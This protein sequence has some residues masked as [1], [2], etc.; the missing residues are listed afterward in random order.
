MAISLL[1]KT[2]VSSCY[3]RHQRCRNNTHNTREDG[4]CIKMNK[5]QRFLLHE[6]F[7]QASRRSFCFTRVMNTSFT[8]TLEHWPCSLKAQSWQISKLLMRWNLKIKSQSPT[9][10]HKEG[11]KKILVSLQA[12]GAGKGPVAVPPCSRACVGGQLI[13]VREL[14]SPSLPPTAEAGVC[15]HLRS[16]QTLQFRG[17]LTVSEGWDMRESLEGKFWAFFFFAFLSWQ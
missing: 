17:S 3:C 15:H 8:S 14:P 6:W 13:P 10:L 7:F 1:H 11:E 12:G 16:Q 2:T 9:F 5:W 4:Y